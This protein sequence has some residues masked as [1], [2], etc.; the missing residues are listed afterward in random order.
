MLSVK[1]KEK[2]NYDV[3]IVEFKK[4]RGVNY[5]EGGF[6]FRKLNDRHSG[7]GIDAGLRSNLR[8]LNV[9]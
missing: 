9:S 5:H 8:V 4:L 2:R 6:V 3:G 1:R 7:I